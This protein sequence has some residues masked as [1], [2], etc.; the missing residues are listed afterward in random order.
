MK[1]MIV[2]TH[3]LGTGHLSRAI[4]LARGFQNANHHVCLVS[5]GAAAAQLDTTGLR[6]AQLPALRSD[7]VNFTRLLTE[8]GELADTDYLQSR[9]RILLEQLR[10]ESPD[11]LITELFPFGRRSLSEEFGDLLEAATTLPRR[12]LILSSIRD[13]LAPPSKPAKAER[14]D[15]I[16]GKYYDGVL[17]HSDPEVTRLN[18]SWPVS[19]LLSTKL[20]YTGYVAPVPAGNHPNAEG[21]GEILVSAGGGEVGGP[22]F[23][24]AIEAARKMTNRRWRLLVGGSQPAARIS[25]LSELAQGLPVT[26]EAARPDFRQMLNHAAVSVSMCGYNSAMDLLQSGIPATLIPFDEGNEVEQ[27]LRA[28]NLADL[29]AFEVLPSKSLDGTSLAASV[30]RLLAAERRSGSAYRFD[31]AEESVRLIERMIEARS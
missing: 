20:L 22:I 12:P 7:G 5:G 8:K 19:P 28:Q 10:S 21:E 24:A 23:R 26:I 15:A 3:L 17:V 9:S 2:V 16:I 31:G 18:T 29:P 4:T 1:V 25:E 30:S 27:G 14:A 13:I 6:V 11:V